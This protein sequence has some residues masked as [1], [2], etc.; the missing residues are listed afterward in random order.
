MTGCDFTGALLSAFFPDRCAYCGAVVPHPE[1]MCPECAVKLPVVEGETCPLCGCARRDC[2]C[3]NHRHPYDR[4]IA[5]L[6]YEGPARHVILRMK[7]RERP[8]VVRELAARMIRAFLRSGEPLPDAVVYVPMTRKDERQRGFNQSRMLAAEVAEGL[9]VP[10]WA[11][12]R[13]VQQTRPQKQLSAEQRSGNVLGV[14]DAA[15]DMALAGKRLLL[16]DDLMTTGATAGEC[17]KVLKLYGA[18]RVVL[19]AAAITRKTEKNA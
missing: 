18:E 12:L 14:F 11:A 17:A 1:R 4:C 2:T 16:V 15:P 7:Q 8:Y 9:A 6:Y 3:E 19:L 5:P 13:K 10:L